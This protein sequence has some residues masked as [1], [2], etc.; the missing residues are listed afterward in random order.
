VIIGLLMFEFSDTSNGVA[1]R[2]KPGLLKT[3]NPPGVDGDGNPHGSTITDVEGTKKNFT[4]ITAGVPAG[5][6]NLGRGEEV[7]TEYVA[8]QDIQFA[9]R[10]A[11]YTL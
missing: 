3:R 9:T 11:N 10:N 7:L 5:K 1:E 4:E 2:G 8:T 6:K